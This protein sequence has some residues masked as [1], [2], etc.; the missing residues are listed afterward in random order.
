M[1]FILA[2]FVSKDLFYVSPL[3]RDESL[4]QL[5]RHKWHFTSRSFTKSSVRIICLLLKAAPSI[6]TN[7]AVTIRLNYQTILNDIFPRQMYLMSLSLQLDSFW[8]AQT[9]WEE[10]HGFEPDT[11]FFTN[12][13]SARLICGD[14]HKDHSS[15]EPLRWKSWGALYHIGVII[16]PR[17]GSLTQDHPLYHSPPTHMII[18]SQHAYSYLQIPPTIMHQNV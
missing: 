5:E 6:R 2:L 13:T 1:F 4:S 17:I 8:A 10:R 14:C 3:R 15:S 11:R 18:F 7:C 12:R 16:D 9:K